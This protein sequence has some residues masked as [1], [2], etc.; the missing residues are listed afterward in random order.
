M[1]FFWV[2]TDGLADR[3]SVRRHTVYNLLGSVAP[4]LVGVV[5]VPIYLR[6]IGDARY[7]VLA[8]VWV[9]LGYFGL[10]DP[11]IVRA[12]AY[13]IARLHAP[14]QQ[15]EREDVFW[16]ALTINALF[17]LAG[18]VALYVA[19]RLVVASV[20]KMPENI[21]VEVLASLPWLAASVPVSIV[22][23]VLAGVL[24]ARERFAE[25]N[26]INAVSGTIAQV[27]PLAVALLHG[28]SLAWLI[29]A[30]LLS[31]LMG[32][33]PSFLVLLKSMPLGVGGRFRRSCMR[34]LFVYG[35]WITL[36]NLLNPLLTTMDRMLIGSLLNAEAV[37]FY[38]VPFNLV[39]RVSL[40]PGAISTSLFPKLSRGSKTDK[41]QLASSSVA[42]LAAIMTPL[43]VIIMAGFPTFMTHWVG[44]RFAEHGSSVGVILL[45]GM[46]INS[47]A[48]IPYAHLQASERPDIVAKFHAIEVIPFLGILWAGMHAFGLLGAAWAWTLRVTIDGLL[49]FRVAGLVR[50]SRS[51]IGGAL[52]VL[53]A[54]AFSPKSLLSIKALPEVLVV[55]ATLA[56]SWGLSATVRD[57]VLS[58]LRTKRREPLME[59]GRLP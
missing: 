7:G 4:M 36:T 42:A 37:A 11:G 48:F 39:S 9:F 23:S 51:L 20:F 30:V 19:A 14:E 8:L 3:L 53:T 29:P 10:F 38:S 26:L 59:S 1:E 58:L 28:P 22:T 5:T 17:G 21:R 18:G 41:V 24:E 43:I 34:S 33:L 16:T 56:W 31:R 45:A 13:H 55:I 35:G 52:L 49:L 15:R 32:V 50:G 6:L 47:L 54:A 25:F 46:W 40:I 57:A 27:A 2:R 12:A 44:A